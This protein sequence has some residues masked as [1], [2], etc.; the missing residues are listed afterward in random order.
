MTVQE[1]GEAAVASG[2]RKKAADKLAPPLARSPLPIRERQARVVLGL[3]FL[4][5]TVKYL[6]GT[7]T[8]ARR[9]S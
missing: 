9:A 3:A 8:R 7:L 1:L 2:W 4:G 5:I 6:A